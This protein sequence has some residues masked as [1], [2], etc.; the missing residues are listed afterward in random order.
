[1]KSDKYVAYS[2]YFDND[3]KIVEFAQIAKRSYY[4]K[5]RIWNNSTMNVN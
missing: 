3:K 5:F 1:M 4:A 2:H